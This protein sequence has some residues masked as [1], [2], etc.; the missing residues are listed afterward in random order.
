[1]ANAKYTTIEGDRWDLIAFKAYG[2][3]LE[4]AR[5]V[6]ANPNIIMGKT[7]P[8]GIAINVPIVSPENDFSLSDARLPP[9][10]RNAS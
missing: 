10:K 8:A 7:L 5:I 4:Y 2:N 3:A 1:M 9:W 6:R